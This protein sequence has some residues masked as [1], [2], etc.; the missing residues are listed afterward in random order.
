ME[1]QP[2]CCGFLR[3]QNCS[4]GRE[5]VYVSIAQIRR[6][7][8]KNGDLVRGKTRPRREGDRYSAL[9]YVESINGEPPERSA[10]RVPFDR[11]TPVHPDR[12]LTLEPP[13][14]GGD[15]AIR[16]LDF[17]APIGLGQRALIVAPPKAGKTVLLKKIAGAVEAGHPDIHLMML[18][19]DER[20]EEVTDIRRSVAGELVYSTFDAP[21]EHHVRVS[22]MVYERAQRLVEQGRDVVVLMDSLTRL[23]RAYNALAPGGRAMS[24]G[25]APG[26]LQRP[27]RFFG[28]ARNV[29]GG[30]S[31]T[32]IATALVETGS[33][34]D[35]IIYEE[36]KGTGNA[37]IHLDRRLSERRIF[38]AID[39]L[40]SGTR[41]EELLLSPEELEGVAAVRR[42]LTA[43]RGRDA[44]E[45]LLG[46][47]EK[48]RTN[49][50]FFKRLKEW[51]AIWEKEGYNLGSVRSG[52]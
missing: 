17:I 49:Q 26:V 25:L 27:K 22:E 19:I 43:A 20:P 51:L 40:R 32:I 10:Q 9:M 41:R 33:R 34:M 7:G 37:E 12:R 36:F 29:E 14:G 48:T 5:D 16:T 35:D 50:E 4:P 31:L 47:L 24:G 52:I 23:S 30:G 8:M 21:Q 28:A 46:M 15:L 1:L 11:L 13:Q 2:D 39:L 44:T 3:V 6:F 38:P 45:Q 42:V 18:L